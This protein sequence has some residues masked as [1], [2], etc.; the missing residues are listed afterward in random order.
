MMLNKTYTLDKHCKR[1]LSFLEKDDSCNDWSYSCPCL[2]LGKNVAIKK[3]WINLEE[4]GY[5]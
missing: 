5:I 1:L 2:I 4:K 3:T